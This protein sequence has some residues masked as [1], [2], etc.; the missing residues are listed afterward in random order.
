MQVVSLPSAPGAIEDLVV[1][2]SGTAVTIGAYDGVHLG[3]RE[4]LART[5]AEAAARKCPSAVITF[6][7]HPASVVR[8]ESAPLLLT[9]LD[10]KLE[11]LAETGV[12]LAVVVQFDRARSE[13]E[14][15]EFVRSV[16]VGL[17]RAR[18]VVVGHDF[19]FGRKRAGDVELLGR[20]GAELGFDVV[21]LRLVTDGEEA[22][23]STRIRRLVAEGEVEAAAGLL[24]RPHQVRGR[25]E[26]GDE[27][28]RALG[29]PT[30]NVAVAP[31]VAVPADGVYAGW[32][33]TADGVRRPACVSVGRRPT[34]YSDAG[35]A[36]VEPYL[37]DFTGDLY[38]Q[39]VAVDFV[40]RQRRQVRFDSATDLVAQMDRDVALTR[41]LLAAPPLG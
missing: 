31:T 30:A 40:A 26:H 18:V 36:L 9:D 34:F 24:G 23:S 27:R 13:E 17:L 32:V 39:A 28:G 22:V 15:D 10:Q 37:L 6:D 21:G 5:R 4:L 11:L 20:L 8:P 41:R 19:H 14:P 35:E 3:H 33:R 38:D 12:D 7:R 25:V 16:L 29:Y 1:A 2:S